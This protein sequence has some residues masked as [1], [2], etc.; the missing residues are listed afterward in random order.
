MTAGPVAHVGVDV[1]GTTTRA[2]AFDAALRPVAIESGPT[3]HGPEPIAGRVADLVGVLRSSLDTSRCAPPIAVCL[4]GRVDV[5]TGTVADAVNLGIEAPVAMGAL[6]AGSLGCAARLENDVNAAALGTFHHLGLAADA[7]LAFVNV[8][9]GI[10]AG[11]VLGGRLWRGATGGAGEIGHI[12]MR[13]DAPPCACGQAGCAEAIGSGRAVGHD[14]AR[15]DDVFA[16][17]A[18]AVQLCVLTLDVDLVAIGGGLTEAGRPFADALDAALAER[19]AAS[20]LLRSA[21]LRRR[22][23]LAPVGVPLGAAGAVLAARPGAAEEAR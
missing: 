6:L 12:P 20:A 15:R 4:P 7:S 21:G 17:V 14:P 16:A 22:V 3:P 1:G 10:A 18:W 5:A 8:G 23:R 9:T 11:F 2:V 13:A 19:E